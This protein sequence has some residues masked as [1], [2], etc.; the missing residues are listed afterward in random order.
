MGKELTL[1]VMIY[2]SISL[3]NSKEEETL[4]TQKGT[5][6]NTHL[7]TGREA[8]IGMFLDSP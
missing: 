7:E 5:D 2:T 8:P 3:S 1:K 6:M 4:G